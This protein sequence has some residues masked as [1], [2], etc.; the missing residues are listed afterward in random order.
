ML[1]IK[2]TDEEGGAGAITLSDI[3]NDEFEGYVR[4]QPG[5]GPDI[6]VDPSDLLRALH[7]LELV[8]KADT[9][10]LCSGTPVYFIP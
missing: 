9:Q 1:Q 10:E 6:I 7:Y 4:I 8:V 2:L 5:S 3:A